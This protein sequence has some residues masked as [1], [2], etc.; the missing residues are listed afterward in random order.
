MKALAR[1]CGSA[2]SHER[3]LLDYVMSTKIWCA[4][5]RIANCFP[6]F[7]KL[8]PCC[9]TVSNTHQI[10]IYICAWVQ[11]E[12]VFTVRTCHSISLAAG[13]FT[14]LHLTRRK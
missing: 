11:A 1:L 7:F 4:Q 2:G 9:V 14:N 10:N 8:K 5:K 12:T 13:P 3:L 6:I